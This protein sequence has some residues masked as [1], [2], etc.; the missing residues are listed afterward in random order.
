MLTVMSFAL[1]TAAI[2]P[3][4]D[5]LSPIWDALR[6]GR[7]ALAAALMLVAVAAMV[8]KYGSTRVPW[9]NSELGSA[10]TVLVGS[11]GAAAASAMTGGSEPS[12]SLAWQ[13][14]V[15]AIG[16]SGGYSLVKQLLVDPVLRPLSLRAPKWLQPVFSVL[17]WPFDHPTAQLPDI[18][19]SVRAG[20][21]A[22]RDTPPEGIR[23]ITGEPRDLE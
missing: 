15:I 13:A 16:A 8:R 4:I 7:P 22:L 3:D 6:T 21:S 5:V 20:E 12:W 11:F 14:L 2:S 19:G 18:A 23:R 10:A 17:F 1:T 9:L